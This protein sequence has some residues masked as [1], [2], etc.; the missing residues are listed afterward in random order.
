[1]DIADN[2]VVGSVTNNAFRIGFRFLQGTAAGAGLQMPTEIANALQ[3]QTPAN[4]IAS[5]TTPTILGNGGLQTNILTANAVPTLGGV[6]LQPGAIISLNICENATGGFTWT[7]PAAFLNPKPIN[8]AASACTFETFQSSNG[9]TLSYIGGSGQSAASG[10]ATLV[11]GT[12]TVSTPA[13]CTPGAT[14]NYQLTNCG[15]AGITGTLSI[16]TVTAGTSFVI[17][18]IVP[19][20]TTVALD[21]SLACWKIN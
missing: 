17:N 7:W 12:V 9:T 20:G 21:T 11:A 19:G 5:S 3:Y 15:P 14:C 6:A 13:S 18:S 10:T 2:N 8:T 1:V 16:G 4:V